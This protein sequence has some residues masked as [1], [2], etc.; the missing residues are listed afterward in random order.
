MDAD[1]AKRLLDI[2]RQFYQTFAG[3][4]SETRGRVQPGVRRLMERIPADADV[5]DIGCGNGNLGAALRE[6]GHTGRYVGVDFSPGL[7]QAAQHGQDEYLQA[8]LSEAGWAEAL[9]GRRFPVVTCFAV[10]HH[11]P[12]ASRQTALLRQAAGLLA[13]G[14]RLFVSNWQFLN[15]AR[16]RGRIQAW[17]RVGLQAAQV[18]EGDYLLDWR[19]GGEGLRYAHHFGEEELRRLAGEAGLEVEEVFWS[20]GETGNLGMYMSCYRRGGL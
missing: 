6:T 2:N 15:S 1:T 9:A 13:E 5:L 7:L 12:G 20:D 14:G 16:L 17:E 10:L 19:S 4:F 3:A 11:I 18:D 8:D